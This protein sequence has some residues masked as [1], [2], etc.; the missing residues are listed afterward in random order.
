[1]SPSEIREIIFVGKLSSDSIPLALYAYE[2]R[3]FTLF[4]GVGMGIEISHKI[5]HVSL[6][7]P[8]YTWEIHHTLG[9]TV[10]SIFNLCNEKRELLHNFFANEFPITDTRFLFSCDWYEKK[11]PVS[12]VLC[13][14]CVRRI[15]QLSLVL[16]NTPSKEVKNGHII[17]LS[18]R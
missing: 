15:P 18:D 3:P 6:L 4:R 16:G 1:M 12:V 2:Q 8:W 9:L 17:P 14:G 10:E 13:I 7:K 5:I 11:K